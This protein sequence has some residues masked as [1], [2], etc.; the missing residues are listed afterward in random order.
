[1]LDPDIPPKV[2]EE[3]NTDGAEGAAHRSELLEARWVAI[4]KNSRVFS[5]LRWIIP[6][7]RI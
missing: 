2:V 3:G 4:G 5:Q 7:A 6:I 1:M